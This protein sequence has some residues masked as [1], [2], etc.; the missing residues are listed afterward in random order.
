MV[1]LPRRVPHPRATIFWGLRSTRRGDLPF[2]C[3][4]QVLAQTNPQEP[5]YICSSKFSLLTHRLAQTLLQHHVFFCLPLQDK[6]SWYRVNH[7]SSFRSSEKLH[8]SCWNLLCFITGA[9]SKSIGRSMFPYHPTP[10]STQVAKSEVCRT[11]LTL[12]TFSVC[13]TWLSLYL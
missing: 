1:W 8:F 13:Q 5:F 9:Q 12:L 3:Y 2:L 10:P 4:S 7:V 11:A 6:E